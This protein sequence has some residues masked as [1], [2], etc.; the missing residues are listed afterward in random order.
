MNAL[1]ELDQVLYI[2]TESFEEAFSFLLQQQ[3]VH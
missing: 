2:I 3:S 1:M